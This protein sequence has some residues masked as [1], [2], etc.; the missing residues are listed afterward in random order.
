MSQQ[1]HQPTGPT[2]AQPGDLWASVGK[3]LTGYGAGKYRLTHEYLYFETGGF[4]TNAQQIPT[5]LIMDVDMRQSMTQKARNLGSVVVHIDRG[6]RR[7]SALIDD[8]PDFREAVDIINRVASHARSQYLQAQR[9][10]NINYGGGPSP[11][12][13]QAPQSSS[14]PAAPSPQSNPE[15]EGTI[16]QLRA[17]ADMHHRKV[18][19]DEQFIAEMHR[20]LPSL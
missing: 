18:I 11:I 2:H 4:S 16:A 9:T 8:I 1:P 13:P 5:A 10:Q 15:R 19:G 3:P 7:E 14:A 17:I 6:G 12:P 20:L